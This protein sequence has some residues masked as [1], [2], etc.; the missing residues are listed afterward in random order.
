VDHKQQAELIICPRCSEQAS[1]S[2]QTCPVCG[3][4]FICDITPVDS[5]A[6]RARTNTWRVLLGLA[7]ILFLLT[8][9]MFYHTGYYAYHGYTNELVTKLGPDH[10]HGIAINGPPDYVYRTELA[11]ALL[12][13]RA[14]NFYF[15]VKQSVTSIDYLSKSFLMTEEGRKIRLEGIGGL[16]NPATGR[17]QLAY[18]TVFPTGRVN[19][20]DRDVFMLAGVLVH[21]LRHIELHQLGLAPGGW[22]EE[23]LCE[24]AAYDALKRMEA[25]GGVMQRYEMYLGDPQAK[26]YQSWYDWYKQ[27]E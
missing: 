13:L 17:V 21:E 8:S 4:P 1:T 11:L 12:E 16:A 10:E 6:L 25:P 20:W 26:R 5:A 18:T 19:Y 23:V 27:W 24:T 2:D 7:A 9:G 14:P 3:F 22:Y 15:R